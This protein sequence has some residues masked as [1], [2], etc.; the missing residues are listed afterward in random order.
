MNQMRRKRSIKEPTTAPRTEPTMTPARL[1]WDDDDKP[2]VAD[3]DITED[4][5][6]GERVA[7]EVVEIEDG[8]D[9]EVEG[10]ADA[11][12]G[13]AVVVK[14]RTG[15]ELVGR[16][17]GRL[18]GDSAGEDEPPKTQTPSVPRGI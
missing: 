13:V 8:D 5:G 4:E 6:D 11:E 7:G 17:V 3:E 2:W 9:D 14:V 10:S 18:D 15:P 16:A 12:V 1:E